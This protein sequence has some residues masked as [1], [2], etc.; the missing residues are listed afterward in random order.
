MHRTQLQS[1]AFEWTYRKHSYF[2]KYTHCIHSVWLIYTL[3]FNWN[4]VGGDFTHIFHVVVMTVGNRKLYFCLFTFT[5]FNEWE[6]GDIRS[7]SPCKRLAINTYQKNAL[8]S[9]FK[10]EAQKFSLFAFLF[11]KDQIDRSKWQMVSV[12]VLICIAQSKL[13]HLSVQ[14]STLCKNSDC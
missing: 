14:A 8:G 13:F 11:C 1:V 7:T 12:H 6:D 4:W 5:M 9:Y 3:I 10:G 2:W